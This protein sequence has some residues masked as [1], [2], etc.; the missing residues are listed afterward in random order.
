MARLKHL[1]YEVIVPVRYYDGL[2]ITRWCKEHFGDEWDI[3]NNPQGRWKC[4]WAGRENRN[5][6]RWCFA[7]E[8]DSAW[9]AL[10]WC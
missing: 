9:F 2:E 4:F 6:S 8:K 10:R 3:T 5:S 1:D 7:D